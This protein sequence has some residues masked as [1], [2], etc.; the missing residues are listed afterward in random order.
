MR[1]DGALFMRAGAAR[2]HSLGPPVV[3]DVPTISWG[4]VDFKWGLES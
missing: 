2:W 3:E 4:P 1:Q